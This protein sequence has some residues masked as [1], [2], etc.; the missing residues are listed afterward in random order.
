M[1]RKSTEPPIEPREFTSIAE[2]DRAVSK[3]SRRIAQVEALDVQAVVFEDSGDDDV[4]E[5]NVRE[6]IREVFGTNSPEFREHEYIRVWAGPMAIGMSEHAIAEGRERGKKQVAT[7]LRGLI[8]RLEEKKEELAEDE[9]T[10]STTNFERLN[11]HPRIATVANDLFFDC[12]YFEAVFAAAKSLINMVKEKSGKHDMDGAPL[13]RTVFS[14][15]DP[16][17][18]INDLATQ[19]DEDEQEGMMHLFEGAVLALRNPG[20][21]AFP[22]GSAQRA[23]ECIQLLS[24]LAYQVDESKRRPRSRPAG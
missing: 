24:L 20:G 4:V 10:G 15:K 1:A 11:L 9:P 18:F 8:A 12:Y 22:Q 19:V 16:I 14:R 6:S 13:M 7:I 23:L 17:L 3:L 2:I 21:H 5:S